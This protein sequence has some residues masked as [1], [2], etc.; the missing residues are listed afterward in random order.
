MSTD[1]CEAQYDENGNLVPGTGTD[2]GSG[3]SSCVTNPNG[4]VCP[5]TSAG[6]ECKPWQLSKSNDNC[7]IDS[8][9][10]ENLLIGGADMNV[11]KL[12]GV[13]EQGRLVDLT[14]NGAAISGGDSAGFPK[15]QAFTTFVTQWRS[16]QK[17]TGVTSSAYIGYDFGEIKLNNG[18]NRYSVETAVK[19]NIASIK[20]KQGNN[21]QNRATK[22]RIERSSDMVKWYG[23]AV[24]TLPDDNCWNTIL[25]NNSV[26]MRYWRLR[27]IEFNGGAGDVWA[28]Q[29]L[30]FFDYDLTAIDNI[31]DKIWNE[32]RDRDYADQSIAIK[33][34]YD[35]LD[36]QSDMARF[37][38]EL[39]SQTY[40]L[41]VS[42]NS[43]VQRLGR[44]LV[45]GDIIEMPSEQQYTPTLQPIKKYMEVVDVGWSPDGYT[46]GWQ[47]LLQRVIVSPML[48][49]QETAD[50]FGGLEGY[51]DGTGFFEN[52]AQTH[53]MD[54]GKHP[55]FQDYSDISQTI[56]E[57]ATD[58][59]HTP[60][61]GRDPADI[62][63]FS[64]EQLQA[65]E[66]QQPGAANGLQNIGLNP[67]QL[68]VEDGLPP[69]GLP[70][71]EG[72]EFPPSPANGDFHRLTYIGIDSSIPARLFRYS[73]AKH[74][75][76]FMESDKRSTLKETKPI[77]QEFLGSVGKIPSEDI[78]K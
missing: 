29:A 58:P 24:V 53:G 47:P 77:L 51:K 67:R 72:D 13:H 64:E 7:F 17:G 46:P 32:N 44:P 34:S 12:L 45:I 20:I 69:N 14:E 4:T 21:A 2:N 66:E 18:R 1:N 36:V 31:E 55:V 43:V 5:A 54:D 62:T 57:T 23:A 41:T 63:Q 70:Y 48:A 28:V 8:V 25:F 50:I 26:P 61:R 60:E 38:I 40:Y 22:V 65:A 75:W 56:E 59:Q 74:R 35:L 33:A 78:A 68:Y 16:A 76:V 9:I 52:F 6:A 49:T 19:H 30:E 27:P 42:F 10:E 73:V 71:T 3:D 11:F 15:A 39:P 37:G